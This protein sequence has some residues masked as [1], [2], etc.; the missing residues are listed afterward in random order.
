[1]IFVSRNRIL[2]LVALLT[3]GTQMVL[4]AS[5]YIGVEKRTATININFG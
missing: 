3:L 5:E 1:M 4:A 2:S